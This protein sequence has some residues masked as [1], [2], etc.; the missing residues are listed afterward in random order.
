VNVPAIAGGYFGRIEFSRER[1]DHLAADPKVRF[2]QRAR[3]QGQP[4]IERQVGV[5]VAAEH[6]KKAEQ[7]RARAPVSIVGIILVLRTR[8]REAYAWL[9]G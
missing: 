2:H 9:P 1:R 4:L 7:S 3:R 5:A 6:L 8:L